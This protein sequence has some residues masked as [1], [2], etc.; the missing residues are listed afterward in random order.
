MTEEDISQEFRLEKIKE[1]NNYFI[2]E[3]DQNQLLS[4]KNPKVCMTL[5]KLHWTLS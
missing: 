4:N 2:K 1:I 3:T 5:N